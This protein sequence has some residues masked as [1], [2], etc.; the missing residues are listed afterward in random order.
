MDLRELAAFELKK[1]GH[2]SPA[3]GLCAMEA[4]ALL[5]G[6]THG[7]QPD[8]TCPVIS[9]YIRRANDRLPDHQRQRLIPFLPKLVG[10]VEPENAPARADWAVWQVFAVVLPDVVSAAGAP[11]LARSMRAVPIYDWEAALDVGSWAASA[12]AEIDQTASRAIA[13]GCEALSWARAGSSDWAAAGAASAATWSCAA[14]GTE[15]AWD[16]VFRI[17]EGMLVV[18]PNAAD[19]DR[20]VESAVVA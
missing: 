20:G 12:M 14:I 5:E 1:G 18:G 3:D 10:T 19:V 7:A 15:Q 11:E 6:Q 2:V 4:V 9:A 16:H 13:W 8:C 17:L